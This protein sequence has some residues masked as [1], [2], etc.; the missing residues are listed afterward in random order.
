MITP[1]ISTEKE[2]LFNI[3]E[4]LHIK[5][6]RCEGFVIVD[7]LQKTSMAIFPEELENLIDALQQIKKFNE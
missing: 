4:E 2:L 5:A 3:S 7:S 6:Y 1:T